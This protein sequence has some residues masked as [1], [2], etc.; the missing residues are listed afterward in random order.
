MIIDDSRW[1]KISG[2]GGRDEVTRFK[3]SGFQKLWSIFEPN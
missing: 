2:T 1:Y 3:W